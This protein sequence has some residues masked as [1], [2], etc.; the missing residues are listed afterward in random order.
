LDDERLTKPQK[1]KLA[2]KRI[3]GKIVVDRQI[4]KKGCDVLSNEE[5]DVRPLNLDRNSNSKSSKMN[6]K[7]LV[8][9]PT[10]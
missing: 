1:N 10:S 3:F 9:R 6:L 8:S 4:K 7:I 5:E 2:Q